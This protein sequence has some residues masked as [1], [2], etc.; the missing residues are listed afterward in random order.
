MT[1]DKGV[2][3]E[4]FGKTFNLT[5]TSG[6]ILKVIVFYPDKQIEVVNIGISDM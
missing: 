3:T 6:M 2:E 1:I 5:I 4:D